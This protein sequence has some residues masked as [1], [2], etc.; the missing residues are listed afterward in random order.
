MS[1]VFL[2]FCGPRPPRGGGCV[3]GHGRGRMAHRE[4]ASQ[5]RSLEKDS[6]AGLN[7]A[8]YIDIFKWAKPAG[9]RQIWLTTALVMSPR[10]EAADLGSSAAQGLWK[11]PGIFKPCGQ[12]G[13]ALDDCQTVSG[14]GNPTWHSELHVTNESSHS[15]PST[16][17]LKIWSKFSDK[18]EYP[19]A[20][21]ILVKT[22]QSDWG[23]GY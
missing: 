11:V 4:L 22:R 19:W 2:P 17:Y 13:G 9:R 6:Q 15:I 1:R 21:K 10:P 20:N 23:A 5:T 12:P 7:G 14:F 18:S 3:F 8:G 16:N